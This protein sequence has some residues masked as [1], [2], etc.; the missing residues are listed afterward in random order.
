MSP[1]FPVH[2]RQPRRRPL[3]SL[4]DALKAPSSA[5]RVAG[6]CWLSQTCGSGQSPNT[7]QVGKAPTV[8]AEW[9]SLPHVTCGWWF[10]A[11]S[12]ARIPAINPQWSVIAS[13]WSWNSFF[14][15]WWPGQWLRCCSGQSHAVLIKGSFVTNAKADF[16]LPSSIG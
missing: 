15:F 12:T 14:G 13:R 3:F 6:P 4:L 1:S 2:S 10:A 16:E 9:L 7:F 8:T 5:P 11:S